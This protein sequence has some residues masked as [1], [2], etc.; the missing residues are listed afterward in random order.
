MKW[1]VSRSVLQAAANPYYVAKAYLKNQP[2]PIFQEK[3]TAPED[4]E[5]DEELQPVF[6]LPKT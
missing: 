1:I 2:V 3:T 4:E 6:K 5:V